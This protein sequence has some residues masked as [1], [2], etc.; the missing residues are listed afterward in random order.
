MIMRKTPPMIKP[1]KWSCTTVPRS[2]NGS[3]FFEW[4]LASSSIRL[5]IF[6]DKSRLHSSDTVSDADSVGRGVFGPAGL[7]LTGDPVGFL[8]FDER[9]NNRVREQARYTL[10]WTRS[11]CHNKD[12]L[13]DTCVRRGHPCV[14]SVRFFKDKTSAKAVARSC[15]CS[16]NLPKII[17]NIQSLNTFVI[18]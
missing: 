13:K 8:Q 16:G 12:L 4:E 9:T 17:Q 15:L 11:R 6:I 3:E 7:P 2:C 18:V 10:R 5:V 14:F 1:R